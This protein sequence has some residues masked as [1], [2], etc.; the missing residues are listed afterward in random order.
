MH[1]GIGA[2]DGIDV[3][4]VVDIQV[5]GLDRDLAVLVRALANATLV[6][7]VVDGRDVIP[8]LLRTVRIADIDRAHP[9]VEM[10]DEYHAIIVDRR[11]ALVGR[12]RAETSARRAE[13]AA[14]LRNGPGGNAH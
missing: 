4:A 5:V 1:S 6:G 10:R 13:V 7:L 3:A 2:I 14:V 9:G 8:D 11:E 12:M